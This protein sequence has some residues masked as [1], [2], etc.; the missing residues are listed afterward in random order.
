[1]KKVLKEERKNTCVSTATRSQ[2]WRLESIMD[3][4]RE[5]HVGG[6]WGRSKETGEKREDSEERHHFS[7]NSY[8]W[9]RT[10]GP[11]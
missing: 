3:L 2:R 8:N 4:V 9:R 1:M 11:E 10:W 6:S 5:V 7:G